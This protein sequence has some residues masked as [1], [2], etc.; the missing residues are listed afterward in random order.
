MFDSSTR[1][2]F[3]AADAKKVRWVGYLWIALNVV[4]ITFVVCAD[5]ALGG[6]PNPPYFAALPFGVVGCLHLGRAG[7]ASKVTVPL[8]VAFGI[9]SIAIFFRYIL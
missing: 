2:P 1:K 5:L 6:F 7:V 8:A 4:A 3:D 9:V